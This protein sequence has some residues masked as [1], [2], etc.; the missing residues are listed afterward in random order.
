MIQYDLPLNVDLGDGFRTIRG[1]FPNVLALPGNKMAHA[2][3]FQITRNRVPEDLTGASILGKFENAN[4]ITIPILGTITGNTCSVNMDQ[5]CYAVPGRLRCVFTLTTPTVGPV[6]LA[7]ITISV[8]DPVGP[9]TSDPL[10]IIP[11]IS[12]LLAMIETLNDASAAAAEATQNANVATAAANSARF[13]VLGI[14]VT[15]AELQAAHPQG[16]EGEAYAVGTAA[17]NV[18]YIWDVNAVAWANIGNI[19]IDF[20]E[21]DPTVPSWAK[22]PTKPGYTAV[23]V[24][25]LPS[26]YTESDPTVPSWAKAPTKPGYTAAEVDAVRYS[27][28][29]EVYYGT[30]GQEGKWAVIATYTSPIIAGFNGQIVEA[31]MLFWRFTNPAECG[32]SMLVASVRNNGSGAYL[33]AVT[34]TMPLPSVFK[35][36]L[37]VDTTG[38]VL[39]AR[40]C[41]SS[42]SLYCT[43]DLKSLGN[44]IAGT[45]TRAMAG[46]SAPLASTPAG[47]QVDATLADQIVKRSSTASQTGFSTDTYLTGAFVRF[48]GWPRAGTTYRLI[49]DVTKTAAGTAA[50]EIKIRIGTAG[51]TSDA[52][53]LTLTFG[54]GTAAVDSGLLEVIV[55]FRSVGSGTAAVVQG[56]ARLTSD[57]ATT[58]ISNAVKSAKATSAG[59]DSTVGNLGIGASYNGGASAAHTVQLVRA[60][61]M[62]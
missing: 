27:Y 11:D 3:I 40:L 54:A 20:T 44:M 15:L 18:I 51:T 43:I 9:D 22:Q 60:E 34:M 46:A 25:A 61:L 58:G 10:D 45:I 24:G 53:V 52:A 6:P 59:F 33:A 48:P 23:E 4:G 41:I 19:P 21:T 5:S 29:A 42:T 7:D 2:W 50:P 12:E 1:L 32:F 28:D 47:T 38:G 16:A 39:T 13:R 49:F 35:F 57:L 37:F 31:L 14:Y 8:S 36:A 55:S 62:I 17:A 26:T 30:S 56:I